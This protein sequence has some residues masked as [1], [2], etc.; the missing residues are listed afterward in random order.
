MKHRLFLLLVACSLSGYSQP[1]STFLDSSRAIDWT[2]AGFTIPNYTTNCATQPT[3]TSSNQ[4]A[5]AANSTAIQNALNS[6][7]TTHNVVNIPAGTY[8]VTSI[9]IKKSNVV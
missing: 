9:P 3:L 7:D 6:C 8:Y 5:A 1:W 2:A 4:S